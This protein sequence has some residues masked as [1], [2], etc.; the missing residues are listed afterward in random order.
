MGLPTFLLLA[1]FP[2]GVGQK[3]FSSEGRDDKGGSD[4]Y[5]ASY[6]R[7]EDHVYQDRIK[8]VRFHQKGWEQGDPVIEKGKGEKL[9]LSFDDLEADQKDYEYRFIHCDADWEPSSLQENQYLDGFFEDR[10][11]SG[12]FSF[13]TEV[14]YTHY[15]LE[16]PNDRIGVTRSG[17][18]LLY[19]F[20]DTGD[21][22]P[23]L[24]RRFMVTSPRNV[25]IE[26]SVGRPTKMDRYDSGQQLRFKIAYPDRDIPNP[27]R[28][29]SVVVQQNGRWDNAVHDPPISSIRKDAVVMGERGDATIFQGMNE[30]RAFDTKILSGNAQG[31]S[32]VER[33]SSG[34]EQ[35][36]LKKDQVRGPKGYYANKDIN[37]HSMIRVREASDPAL[38]GEY[39]RVHFR[40]ERAAPLT[41]GT[42][43]V[44]GSMSDHRC[45]PAY[46]MEYDR[47]AS[48][49]RT[50]IL[51][52]Q[53]YHEYL[54]AYL[55]DKSDQAGFG[56]LEGNFYETENDYRVL[57][58][59]RGQTDRADR[60]IGVESFDSRKDKGGLSPGK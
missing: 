8:T 47:R 21:I 6:L 51:L 20:R 37:G 16:V 11:P 52:K 7:Y 55:S 22:E 10:L 28:S 4:Y 30:Y 15:R 27:K 33:D 9:V 58:Y 40:L 17:N 36:R 34:T 59:Y 44:F 23:V 41:N 32:A 57:V 12:N 2:D 54:Y 42:V 25:E 60:L 14:P 1:C 43:H 24:S 45:L 49:Y 19:V 31:V 50:S 13:D 56:E 3:R 38:S 39:V 35:I 46:R 5:D 26:G 48:A 53:G 18:Y 29:L